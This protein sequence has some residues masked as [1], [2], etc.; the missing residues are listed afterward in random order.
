M[1][2]LL[3]PRTDIFSAPSADIAR[4]SPGDTVASSQPGATVT[5]GGKQVAF[6]PYENN[7][8]TVLAVAGKDFCIVA[9]DT[10]FGLGYSVPTRRVSRVLKL[11][12]KAVIATSGMQAD[13][14]TLHKVLKFKLRQYEHQHAKEMTLAAISQMLGNTLYFKRFFPYYTFNVVG[15]IDEDGEGF[16]YG[17][18]AIGSFERVKVVCSGTGQSMIQPVIDNQVDYKQQLGAVKMDLSLQETVDLVKDCFTS[19][20]ERDIYTGDFVEIC[21][22]TKDGVEIEEFALKKD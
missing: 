12:D 22:I 8:G 13:T 2:N 10:R 14:S 1:S 21:K 6:S 19:A 17:Y 18:D 15:G 11:T 20:G 7:G 3:Y 9:S 5:L 16:A 4:N